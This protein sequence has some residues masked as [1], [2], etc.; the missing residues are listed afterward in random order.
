MIDCHCHLD[1]YP[2]ALKL[3]PQVAERNS[4]TLV[5]TTSPRAWRATS[6]VFAGYD[7]I[8]IALG[9][10]PEVV[11]AKAEEREML[12]SSI[13][14]AEFVGE[15]G[16][17][18]SPPHRTSIPMQEAVFRDILLEC[19]RVGGKVMS[20]HSRNAADRVLTL[21]QRHC[22]LSTPILH[23]FSGTL[24]EIKRAVD[25][26]CWFSVGPAMLA[27]EKGRRL[28]RAIPVDRVLP[29]SDGPFAR[30][31]DRPLLP[32]EAIEIVD[33]LVP[34]WGRQREDIVQQMCLNLS[35]VLAR[36]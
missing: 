12:V 27:G 25:L 35:T 34:L 10:H 23:W 2:E 16:I 18:G 20:I 17:D 7:S 29:E 26:G 21:I 13:G 36:R 9:M 6:R 8:A 14:Q 30:R 1:L 15:V 32:W 33:E 4:F 3:L 5:V 11:A 19:E 31:G 22:R 28:L 24:Q